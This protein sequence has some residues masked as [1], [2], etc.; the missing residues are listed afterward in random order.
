M[1][2]TFRDIIIIENK[3]IERAHRTKSSPE[4]RRSQPRTI[5]FKFYNY[6]DEVKV[7]Q[8][9]KKLKG[10]NVSINEDFILEPLAYRKKLWKGLKQL[11]SDG[12]IA[13]L[14]YRTIVCRDRN[15]SYN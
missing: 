3:I 10:T 15:G 4:T 11:R 14:N 8:N 2:G 5:L 9:E 7:V 12:K 6:K 13:Y 1:Q